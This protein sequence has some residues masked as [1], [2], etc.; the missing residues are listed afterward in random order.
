M[1][2]KRIQWAEIWIWEGILVPELF[3]HM[4][5]LEY[6][7]KPLLETLDRGDVEL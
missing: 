6:D 4:S 3:Q 1:Y 5:T 7:V 2:G